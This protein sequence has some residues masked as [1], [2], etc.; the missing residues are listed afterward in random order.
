MPVG[1]RTVRA[2]GQLKI[3]VGAI[4]WIAGPVL[5][6]IAQ[7]AVRP[8]WRTPYSWLASPVSDLGAVHLPAY[9]QWLSGLE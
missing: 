3:R 9:G 4:M 1:R 7:L 6:L 5:F 8:A 2:D